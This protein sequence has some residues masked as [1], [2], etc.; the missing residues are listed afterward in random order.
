MN[1]DR[2]MDSAADPG[3]LQPVPQRI[4]LGQPDHILVEHMCRLWPAHRKRQRQPAETDI[5]TVGNGLP[6][7]IV[8]RQ[9]S[10]LDA[11]D[12]GLDRVETRI[13]AGAVR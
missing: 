4:A 11:E 2:I 3:G 9:D 12:R 1:R 8:S 13:D 6:T 5:I 7:S 10:E